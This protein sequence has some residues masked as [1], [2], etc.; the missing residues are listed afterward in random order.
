MPS[1]TIQELD[2]LD[3][4]ELM[5]LVEREPDAAL[6]V[7][8]SQHD[9]MVDAHGKMATDIDGLEPGDIDWS[10]ECRT[11]FDLYA[12]LRINGYHFARIDAFRLA[13]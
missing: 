9:L 13:M 12:E 8:Q 7:E 1:Y 4:A 11:D 5:A 6:S 10:V 3:D 2:C